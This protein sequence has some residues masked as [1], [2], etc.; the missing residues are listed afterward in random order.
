MAAA[1]VQR[2]PLSPALLGTGIAIAATQN[3]AAY[4]DGYY[5]GGPVY[6]GGD[7]CYGGNGYGSSAPYFHGH[8]N[9]GW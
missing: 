5:G 3:R 9:A 7:P 4:Y 6:Y 8:P 2:R 1:E